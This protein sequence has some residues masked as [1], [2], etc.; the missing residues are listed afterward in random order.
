[1]LLHLDFMAHLMYPATEHRWF[2]HFHPWHAMASNPWPPAQVAAPDISTSIALWCNARAK[3]ARIPMQLINTCHGNPRNP[4]PFCENLRNPNR[5]R[6][7]LIPPKKYGMGHRPTPIWISPCWSPSSSFLPPSFSLLKILSCDYMYIITYILY[8]IMLFANPWSAA[9]IFPLLF[10]FQWM[11]QN[12]EHHSIP[13]FRNCK[14]HEK[15]EQHVETNTRIMLFA[16]PPCYIHAKLFIKT[17]H[18]IW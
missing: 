6:L 8:H 2:L 17:Y 3:P 7:M 1:M 5:M 12:A 16:L 10:G 4:I 15:G 9:T 13:W 18:N 11:S 14:W